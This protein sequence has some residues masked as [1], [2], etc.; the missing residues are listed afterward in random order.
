L[1]D[2]HALVWA[3]DTPEIFSDTARQAI[4]AGPVY[5]SVVSVW[6]LIVKRKKDSALLAD[7]VDW[8]NRHVSANAMTVLPV[9]AA[10]IAY[11]DKL[12]EIHRDPF[13]RILLCQA[14]IEDLT[15]VTRD[16]DISL[17]TCAAIVRA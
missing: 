5:L 8:W 4:E 1:L 13:D 14:A 16:R 6:E 7:P 15:L 2:T 17:Y 3:I 9:T 10:H 11:L 12:P